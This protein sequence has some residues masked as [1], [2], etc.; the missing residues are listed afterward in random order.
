MAPP[1]QFTYAEVKELSRE[2][3]KV[4]WIVIHDKVYNVT[5]FLEEVCSSTLEFKIPK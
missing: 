2:D 1:R 4:T 5:R 3:G